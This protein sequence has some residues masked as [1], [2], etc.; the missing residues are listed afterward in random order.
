MSEKPTEE[1]QLVLTQNGANK[2]E[3]LFSSPKLLDVQLKRE[4]HVRSIT[5]G[6]VEIRKV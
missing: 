2:E 1:Y 3:V 4:Q 6:Y 5:T